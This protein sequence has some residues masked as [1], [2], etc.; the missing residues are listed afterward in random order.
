MPNMK[1]I[2]FLVLLTAIATILIGTQPGAAQVPAMVFVPC[3]Q[4]ALG[5][6][7]RDATAN[8]VDDVISLAPG[9]TYSYP[10][11]TIR[12]LYVL[13]SN[14]ADR[15]R[16][17]TIEGNGAVIDGTGEGVPVA[18]GDGTVIIRNLIMTNGFTFGCGGGVL[19]DSIMV[20][21]NSRIINNRADSGGGVCNR[22]NSTLTIRNT[23]IADNRGDVEAGG[24]ATLGTLTL[25][26]STISGNIAGEAN[27]FS[28]PNGRE[29]G[30]LIL[31]TGETRIINTTITNNE[32]DEVGGIGG[33]VDSTFSFPRVF[34]SNTII[35]GNRALDN[36]AFPDDQEENIDNE[37]L[38]GFIQFTSSFVVG[39]PLLAPLAANGGHTRTHAPLSGSP[40]VDAGTCEQVTD[41][42]GASR[43]VGITCDI[44]AFEAGG[45]LPSSS[46]DIDQNGVIGPGDTI[47]IVNRLGTN[48]PVADIDDSGFVDA[49]DV[50]LVVGAFGTVID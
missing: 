3:E 6:A 41:Q 1:A 15:E 35:A 31:T 32:A 14:S 34:I 37:D 21:E 12:P 20:I 50:N 43:P 8:G 49:A 25:I 5:A 46:W 38:D 13:P 18:V 24:L 17:I 47:Y 4:F 26:N 10:S 30:M 33:F 28:Y 40:V 27:D 39:D 11:D 29:G 23:E 7:I 19:N 44:G 2:H 36:P 22:D 42:R 16:T 9:C 45:L 48:D